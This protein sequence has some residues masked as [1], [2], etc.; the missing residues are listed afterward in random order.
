MAWP[1]PRQRSRTRAIRFPSGCAS[2]LPAIRRLPRRDSWRISAQRPDE[3]SWNPSAQ[4]R[5][6][7][8]VMALNQSFARLNRI[9]RVVAAVVGAMVGIGIPASFGLV[10]YYA[11]VANLE[12]RT[13]LAAERLAEYV[14]VQGEGW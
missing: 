10:A 8:P 14:Y 2:S 7:K 1:H 6:T 11:K 4:R 3:R 13:G 12:Y 5:P 9:V